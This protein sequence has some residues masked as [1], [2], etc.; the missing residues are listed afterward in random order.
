MR[1]SLTHCDLSLSPLTPCRLNLSVGAWKIDFLTGP[2]EGLCVCVCVCVYR[3]S[4][5][6]I[7]IFI[8]PKYHLWQLK[9]FSANLF[10]IFVCAALLATQIELAVTTFCVVSLG[11]LLSLNLIAKYSLLCSVFMRIACRE[12]E[13]IGECCAVL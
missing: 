1:F 9:V 10:S 5:A 13:R 7:A 12:Y 4:F 8:W 11:L 6:F 3:F 2:S